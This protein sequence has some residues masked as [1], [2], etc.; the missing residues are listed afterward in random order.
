MRHEGSA[1]D[2]LLA[3]GYAL[4]DEHV[5]SNEVGVNVNFNT[6]QQEDQ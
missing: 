1:E 4:S 6:Q 2:F 3:N 5:R